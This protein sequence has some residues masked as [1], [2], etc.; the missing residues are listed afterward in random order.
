VQVGLPLVVLIAQ[1]LGS[2]VFGKSSQDLHM[3][4]ISTLNDQCQETLVQLTSFMQRHLSMA[5]YDAQVSDLKT[6]CTDFNLEINVAFHILR[7]KYT[8]QVSTSAR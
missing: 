3:K 7:P 1:Q 6:M 5:E 2:I 8:T 4:L